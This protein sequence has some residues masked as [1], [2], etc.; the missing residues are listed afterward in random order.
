MLNPVG[1]NFASRVQLKW[2]DRPLTV[3]TVTILCARQGLSTV[4]AVNNICTFT[5]ICT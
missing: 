1:V 4:T 5:A 3:L 2:S